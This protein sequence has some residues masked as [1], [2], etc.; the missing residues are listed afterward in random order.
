MLMHTGTCNRIQQGN[1]IVQHTG[2]SPS[3]VA[4][5]LQAQAP[6]RS[7][8]AVRAGPRAAESQDGAAPERDP[9]ADRGTAMRFRCMICSPAPGAQSHTPRRIAVP[10]SATST[11][12]ARYHGTAHAPH[13]HTTRGEQVGPTLPCNAHGG[14]RS[15]NRD[16]LQVHDLFSC[17]GSAIPCC[18]V[19][20]LGRPATG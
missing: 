19:P 6:P 3:P 11:R 15:R 2:A 13:G 1:C 17:S 8:G 18:N 12:V 20:C 14:R 9:A 7:F 4:F 10:R 5:P 16:A